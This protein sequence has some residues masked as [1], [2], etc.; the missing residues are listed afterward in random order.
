AQELSIF[1]HGENSLSTTLLTTQKLF[2]QQ[3]ASAESL[4][5]EDLE[6]MEGIVKVQYPAGNLQNGIDVVSLVTNTGIFS[7]KGEA[8]KMIQNGGISINRQKVT[9]PQ[10]Q[11]DSMQLLHKKYLLVQR[12]KK[13]YYLIVVTNIQE[14]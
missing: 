12:G 4:T 5:A 6:G 10:M 13:N 2:E 1:V 11:I 7:S 14:A 9:D 3:N 8:K